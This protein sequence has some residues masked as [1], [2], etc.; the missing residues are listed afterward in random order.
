M[1]DI[2]RSD[3]HVLPAPAQEQTQWI[4]CWALVFAEAER[5]TMSPR[6]RAGMADALA[7]GAIPVNWFLTGFVSNTVPSPAP[8][9]TDPVGGP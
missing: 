7:A 5:I 2:V 4:G 9:G 8:S 1:F 6:F 3:G